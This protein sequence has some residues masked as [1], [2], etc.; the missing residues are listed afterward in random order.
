MI[1]IKH[2]TIKNFLSIGNQT[3]SIAFDQGLLTLVLGENLDLG[4][5]GTKNAA[6]KTTIVNGLSYA[7]F[8]G[9][10]T[11]IK[12]E[13]LINKINGKA[14]LATV[15]FDK[16]GVEYRIERGRKP[17]I[18]KFSI[19]GKDQVLQDLDES[20][21]DSRETQK[22]IE[23][24]L[25]MK[26]EMFKHIIALN[27]FTVPFLG[28]KPGE[29]REI[30]EQLLGITQLSEKADALKILIKESKDSILYENTRISTVQASNDRIQQSIDSV[31]RKEKM[32]NETRDRASAAITKDIKRL[33]TI[34]IDIE[35]QDQ[36]EFTK[37]HATKKE[38]DSI[39]AFITQ[40]TIAIDREERILLAV[41]LELINLA[42]HMCH[43]CGQELH[44]DKHEQLLAAKSEQYQASTVAIT[45]YKEEL[46]AL[47]EARHTLG[48]EV[49]CPVVKYATLEQALNHKNTIAALEKELA[50]KLAESNHYLEQ[51]DDLKT[52]AIQEITWDKMNEMVRVKEHQ[53]FLY[54][55]LT[56]KNSFV[57]KRIIDQNLAFLNQRLS[58]YLS[59][60]GLPHQVEFQ[61]DLSVNI[62][63]LG[64]DLDFYNLSRGE[65]NRLILSLSW[66]FRD[67]WENLYQP[68]NLLFIDELL[69]SGLDSSGVENSITVLKQMT[70]ERNK[71][72][73]L[74]SHRDDLSSRVNSVLKVVKEGG[75]THFASDVD[76]IQ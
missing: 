67:V 37:W 20:Q 35:I 10:L 74:I 71:N 33:T 24:I 9:A 63:Q 12:R 28:M 34:D 7:L 64:Q 62:T 49:A 66:S 54:S 52:T 70:R 53:D 59:Q 23:D 72:V 14:M 27:T 50:A 16:D 42:D 22:D 8:G 76:L 58:V 4:G 31:V 73:F 69:D 55:L 15:T 39:D 51:I 17:N 26:H 45:T 57:R 48:A 19:N 32:W 75:F 1:T 18:L 2:L 3:Q 60:L 56:N 40:Q 11:N 44:D 25:G 68:I 30:I 36:R 6:G 13:N 41:E 65:M 5:A 29:Q 61:N 21:G 46:S 38:R 47:V 43:A